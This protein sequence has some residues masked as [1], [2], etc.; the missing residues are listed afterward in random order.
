MDSRPRSFREIVDAVEGR[1]KQVTVY[2]PSLPEWLVEVLGDRHVRIVHRSIPEGGLEPFVVV[3]ADDR[4][5][6]SVEL[7][8]LAPLGGPEA[9]I[10]D[11][12]DPRH[13]AAENERFRGMLADTVFSSLDRRSLVAAAR[14]IEDRAW[15]VAEGTLYASFQSLSA[16]RAQFK[17][18]AALSRRGDL[19]VRVYGRP[20]WSPPRTTPGLHV[21]ET[22]DERVAGYWVVAFDGGGDEGQKCALVAEQ[23]GPSTYAGFWTYEPAVV[24]DVVAVLEDVTPR[25]ERNQR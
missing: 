3:K 17:V 21:H 15:R 23:L 12:G 9:E 6:G 25:T 19:A 18:Y 4:H 20:D 22:D 13:L 1:R 7:S 16:F 5:L 14:E 24:D 10:W 2:A 11:P 8:A